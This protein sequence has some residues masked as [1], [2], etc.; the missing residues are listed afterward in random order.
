MHVCISFV[1]SEREYLL[2]S[3]WVSAGS[4][5][6]VNIALPGR[7]PLFLRNFVYSNQ[8]VAYG[9]RII[10]VGELQNIITKLYKKHKYIKLI[11]GGHWVCFVLTWLV[12]ECRRLL[13]P[14][15]N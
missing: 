9:V 14:L 8:S 11:I 10:L 5:L 7:G 4:C 13:L 6:G 1:A 2:D 3:V 12:Y 15:I